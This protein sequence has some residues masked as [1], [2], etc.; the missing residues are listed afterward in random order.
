M[1]SLSPSFFMHQQ[2][3]QTGGGQFSKSK[4]VALTNIAETTSK[5][6]AEVDAWGAFPVSFIESDLLGMQVQENSSF[7]AMNLYTDT[8]HTYR[9]SGI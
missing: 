5:G 8:K 6:R 9:Q 2:R 4:T 1:A 3:K 7:A